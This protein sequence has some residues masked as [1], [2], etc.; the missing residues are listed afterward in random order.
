[1]SKCEVGKTEQAWNALFDKYSIAD[2]VKQSGAFSISAE[3]IKKFREPRLMAK[4]DHRKNLPSVFK[5]HGFGILPISRGDYLIGPFELFAPLPEPGSGGIVQK[6]SLPTEVASISPNAIFSEPV[7]LNC[8]WN[9]GILQ[10][11]LGEE[12]LFPT[13]SG[14][15]GAKPFEFSIGSTRNA[16]TT[17]VSV[18]GAQIEVDAA[19]E[20]DGSLTIIEA[21]MDLA[22]DFIVRQLYYPYRHFS[23][24]PIHKP[25]RTV[26]L[27]Y[28]A[29]IF[30]LSEYGFS[31][32]DNY[33]SATLLKTARYSLDSAVITLD[34][35]TR[36]MK[37]SK[38]VADADDVPFP[39]A[40]TFERVINLC[41]RLARGP[42]TK[43][44]IEEAYGFDP[45]QADYYFNAAAYLGL[46]QREG[47]KGS[48]V[49]LSNEGRALSD[50][51]LARRNLKLAE[52]I[53][54]HSAFRETFCL[55]LA[56]GFVPDKTKI[57][58]ILLATNPGLGNPEG[59][60]Y[61]RRASTIRHWTQWL[62]SLTDETI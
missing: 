13:L 58:E 38:P 21:K 25:V 35:L 44:D 30:N 49:V 1:M 62:L 14:R 40:D 4:F 12:R 36:L 37:R 2:H 55:S 52:L 18:D 60:T 16:G 39:Q 15:M 45:R 34:D 10:S 47:G 3:Q 9:A 23:M 32:P 20:G 19:Y 6:A 57:R 43:E 53:L 59:E 5:S 7:A 41:E 42:M 50:L 22:E 48:R 17:K 27:T 33:S 31:K 8:A 29:G 24:L 26:F 28:S 51:P 61:A 54:R 46:A 11:F 56:H